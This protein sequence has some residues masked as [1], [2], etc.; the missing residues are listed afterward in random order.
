MSPNN[1]NPIN[2]YPELLQRAER[3]IREFQTKVKDL[4]EKL[5]NEQVAHLAL[6]NETTRNL[7]KLQEQVDNLLDP[8]ERT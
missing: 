4:E 2:P 5:L 7:N 3:T 1:M 8:L 6:I